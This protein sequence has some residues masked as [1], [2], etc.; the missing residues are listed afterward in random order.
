MSRNENEGKVEITFSTKFSLISMS[1]SQ[2]T[3]FCV[4]LLSLFQRN[5]KQSARSFTRE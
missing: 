4:S 5:Y 2:A 1:N 3:T